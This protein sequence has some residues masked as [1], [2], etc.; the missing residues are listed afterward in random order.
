M[1]TNFMVCILL[2]ILLIIVIL[3]GSCSWKRIETFGNVNGNI[4][5]ASS[6][7]CDPTDTN[8]VPASRSTGTQRMENLVSAQESTYDARKQQCEM[9]LDQLRGEI[10]RTR[11]EY[12]ELVGSR[13]LEDGPCMDEETGQWGVR[14]ARLGRGC[15]TPAEVSGVSGTMAPVANVDDEN[16]CSIVKKMTPCVL[17]SEMTVLD[18]DEKCRECFGTEYGMYQKVQCGTGAK[19]RV[20]CEIGYSGGYKKGDFD[21]PCVWDEMWD[22]YGDRICQSTFPQR[23]QI[24]EKEKKVGQRGGCIN[25]QTK[26]FDNHYVR[27]GCND[28][29]T[30]GMYR[31]G[32]VTET[33]ESPEKIE[34]EGNQLCQRDYGMYSRYTGVKEQTNCTVDKVRGYCT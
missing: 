29:Y 13:P 11:A 20:S 34:K 1:K 6:H 17:D 22:G 23:N 16:R 2:L 32:K 33:C 27:F 30:R 26:Q 12:R 4:V 9:D 25:P 5:D 10:D 19:S 18:W 14:M 3:S 8:C 28:I 7:W 24:G 15:F 31:W 21:T